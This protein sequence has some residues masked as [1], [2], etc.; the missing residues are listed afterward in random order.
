MPIIYFTTLQADLQLIK[1]TTLLCIYMQNTQTFCV[2]QIHKLLTL[3]RSSK[4]GKKHIFFDFVN[5]IQ[6]YTQL[7]CVLLLYVNLIFWLT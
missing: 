6:N 2:R 1:Y 5:T 7:C 4:S 3:F